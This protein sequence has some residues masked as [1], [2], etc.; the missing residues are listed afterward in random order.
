M[1]LFLH[2][3]NTVPVRITRSSL[4]SAQMIVSSTSFLAHGS[5][6]TITS[7]MQH[8]LS[9][10]AFSPIGALMYLNLPCGRINVVMNELLGWVWRASWKYPCTASNLEKLVAVLGMGVP[11]F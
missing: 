3:S 11:A 1:L 7:D 10:D 9:D 4:L 8:H 5:P 2:H 6:S